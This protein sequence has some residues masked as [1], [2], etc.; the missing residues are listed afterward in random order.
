[1]RTGSRI[2]S[3]SPDGPWAW[4]S[5]WPI[6]RPASARPSPTCGVTEHEVVEDGDA[7]VV[8]GENT[9]VHTAR[10]L[11]IEP[12]GRCVSWEYLDMYHPDPPRRPGRARP[13]ARPAAPLT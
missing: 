13:T 7:L 12:T 1:M 6:F 3:G 4:T 5:R 2:A 9:A 8:R 10:F 11:G